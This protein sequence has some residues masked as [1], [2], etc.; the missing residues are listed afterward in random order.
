MIWLS[1]ILGW[2]VVSKDTR[3]SGDWRLHYTF[4][5]RLGREEQVQRGTCP[6]SYF[7]TKQMSRKLRIKPNP[8]A[9]PVNIFHL[10]SSPWSRWARSI[11]DSG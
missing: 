5:P 10:S 2:M 11:S 4:R 7:V 8:R 1:T 9:E 3:L 6:L